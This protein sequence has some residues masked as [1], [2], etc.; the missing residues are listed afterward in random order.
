MKVVN[1]TFM[2]T[3]DEPMIVQRH[4]HENGESRFQLEI[5]ERRVRREAALLCQSFFCHYELLDLFTGHFR[6][7]YMQTL[8]C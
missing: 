3:A 7:F 4:D 8:C 1:A 6:I 5:V 2:P